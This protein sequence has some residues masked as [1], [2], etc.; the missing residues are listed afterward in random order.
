M[1]KPTGTKAL[2]EEM[3]TRE[4]VAE[5]VVGPYE[6]VEIKIGGKEIFKDTGPIRLLVVRD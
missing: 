6:A 4:G 2:V 5:Y 1:E 3:A